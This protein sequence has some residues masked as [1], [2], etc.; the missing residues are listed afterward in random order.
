MPFGTNRLVLLYP[1]VNITLWGNAVQCTM[2]TFI[3]DGTAAAG[4]FKLYGYAF[5]KQNYNRMYNSE[6]LKG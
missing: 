5:S 4:P 1:G 3:N 6:F 2:V